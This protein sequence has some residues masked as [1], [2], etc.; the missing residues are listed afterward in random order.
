M[1]TCAEADECVSLQSNQ[2]A[3][4]GVQAHACVCTP[5]YKKGGGNGTTLDVET[6]SFSVKAR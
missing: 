6:R 1:Q 3:E 5:V 2:R 4:E